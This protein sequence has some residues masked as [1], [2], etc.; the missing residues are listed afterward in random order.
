MDETTVAND[1]PA[2]LTMG[3]IV[4]S[5]IVAALVAF[6]L[7]R[8]MRAE[9]EVEIEVSQSALKDRATAATGEFVRSYLAPEM[10]PMLMTVIKD[11]RDYVDR[12]FQRAEQS[13]K[14]F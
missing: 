11:V 1:N 10:K 14:D 5:A 3:A 6:F 8:A 4:A 12:G 9:Q 13:I 7:R 2:R